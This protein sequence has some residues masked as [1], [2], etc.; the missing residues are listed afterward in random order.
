MRKIMLFLFCVIFGVSSAA[1]ANPIGI[2]ILSSDYHVW[3]NLAA[4]LCFYDSHTNIFLKSELLYKTYDESATV[5]ISRSV[6]VDSTDFYDYS[7]T[8]VFSVET[9]S[10]GHMFGTWTQGTVKVEIYPISMLPDP[11]TGEASV[12]YA[13]AQWTFQTCG[14]TLQI[15]IDWWDNYAWSETMIWFSDITTGTELLYGLAQG[16]EFRGTILGTPFELDDVFNISV[17]PSHIYSM[18]MYAKSSSCNDS[19]AIKM[20]ATLISVPEPS[21]IQ[22][23]FI[24]LLSILGISRNIFQK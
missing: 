11:Y 16:I 5:P 2:N 18:R 9:K 12:A 1:Y 4:T 10:S 15:N 21:I 19:P 24:G 20:N 7:G 13:D 22:L 3:G 17:D 14:T 8:D 23:L 6:N